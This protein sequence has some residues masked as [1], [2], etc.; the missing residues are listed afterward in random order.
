[1]S[2]IA[3]VILLKNP[4]TLSSLNDIWGNT[5]AL[6]LSS[7]NNS[8]IS[9]NSNGFK[10]FLEL[11]ILTC[12]GEPLN[13]G[14]YTTPPRPRD[15][16]GFQ[17]GYGA[18]SIGPLI[19]Q[20]L[21]TTPTGNVGNEV[22]AIQTTTPSKYYNSPFFLFPLVNYDY[23]A[24]YSYNPNLTAEAIIINISG[25]DYLGFSYSIQNPFSIDGSIRIITDN[26]DLNNIGNFQ[27]QDTYTNSIATTTLFDNAFLAGTN[28]VKIIE[29]TQ[30][31]ITLPDIYSTNNYLYG[32]DGTI[33]Y[34]Q[35]TNQVSYNYLICYTSSFTAPDGGSFN[36]LS[37]Y[38]N[39]RIGTYSNTNAAT[40]SCLD[41]IS[42]AKK[43]KYNTFETI[44]LIN[45]GINDTQ[46]LEVY[47]TY[48]DENYQFVTYIAMSFSNLDVCYTGD[49][50]LYR[51]DVP[52]GSKNT[53]VTGVKYFSVQVLQQTTLIP[54]SEARWFYFDYS[55]SI[56]EDKQ[57]MFKNRFGAWEYFTFTQDSKKT[58]R[59]NRNVIKKELNWGDIANGNIKASRGEQVISSEINVEF[60]LNSNWISEI[61]F[62][63]LSELLE[64]NDVYILE[65]YVPAGEQEYYPVPIII[66]DTSYEYKTA[67]R[68]QLFNLTINYRYANLKGTQTQ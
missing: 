60:V 62:E 20:H 8:L 29:Y 31:D 67:Y 3:E 13:I 58:D 27:I 41:F 46:D 52:I 64:S 34:Q 5:I 50:K 65:K 30:T 26:S 40:Q 48:Y 18:I 55:C 17:I 51:C 37:N 19:K 15:F 22:Y 12:D 6:G 32:F 33:N 2:K 7:S 28:Q 11:I 10:Y 61:E 9:V 68:D 35:Y 59:I 57:I 63:W 45:T 4:D 21:Y 39:R 49:P 43:V 14:I 24:G 1:M 53:L 38:P 44:S 36:F 47:F 42:I 54:F 16:S 56:Y 66:T 25:D 23:L